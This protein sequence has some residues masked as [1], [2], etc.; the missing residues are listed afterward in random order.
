MLKIVKGLKP[1]EVDVED[2]IL[3]FTDV[4]HDSYV[5]VTTGDED[6]CIAAHDYVKDDEEGFTWDE[7]MKLLKDEDM[8]TFTKEQAMIYI[9][10]REDINDKLREMG[11]DVLKDRYIHYWTSTEHG[12]CDPWFAWSYSAEGGPLYSIHKNMHY[13]IRPIID[14]SKSC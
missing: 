2:S 13:R 10:H 6:F 7:A 1:L 5:R 4:G 3:T 8:T 12:K 14:L 11:G 9:S